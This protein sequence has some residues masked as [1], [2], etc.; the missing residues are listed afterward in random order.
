MLKNSRINNLIKSTRSN[1]SKFK[2]GSPTKSKN[3]LNQSTNF[4]TNN[5]WE[6][7]GIKVAEI[8]ESE[9]KTWKSEIEKLK[10]VNRKLEQNLTE[11]CKKIESYV[12]NQDDNSMN[13]KEIYKF[14]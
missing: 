13:S 11:A 8:V 7:F 12:N 4:M 3:K 10:I 6:T 9:K 1:F 2:S 5:P 14:T